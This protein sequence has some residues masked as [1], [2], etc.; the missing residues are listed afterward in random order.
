M[1]VVALADME[2]YV[3]LAAVQ[4]I[5]TAADV[6]P[7]EVIPLIGGGICT[8][9]MSFPTVGTEGELQMTEICLTMEQRIKLMEALLFIWDPTTGWR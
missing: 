5:I 3:Y 4:C 1:S 6:S 9:I 2:S 8:G 7:G